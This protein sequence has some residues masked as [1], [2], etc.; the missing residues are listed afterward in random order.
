MRRRRQCGKRPLSDWADQQRLAEASK[1]AVSAKYAETIY[2]ELIPLR[3]FY[4]AETYHQKYNLKRRPELARELMRI[5][6]GPKAFMDSTVAARLNGYLG[7]YGSAAQ[8]AWEIDRLG[9]SL[10]ARQLLLEL[11]GARSRRGFG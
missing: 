4:P 6:P 1:A 3:A 11:V 8:L 10:A 5:Y 2:S 9:L 7:G